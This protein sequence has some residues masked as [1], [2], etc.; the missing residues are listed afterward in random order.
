ME[1]SVEQ[2]QPDSSFPHVTF[3]HAGFSYQSL[4]TFF[5]LGTAK[6][7]FRYPI[8]PNTRS[9]FY[10]IRDT[11]KVVCECFR[12]PEKWG[13]GHTVPIVAEELSMEQIFSTIRDVTDKDVHFV[14]LPY[15]E[16]LLKLHRETVNNLR[17]H[18]EV[19]SFDK[20]QMEKTKEIWPHMKKFADLLRETRW[21]ME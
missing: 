21:F 7:E 14:P 8:L 1:R 18:N 19:G 11:G 12:H 15:D 9:P 4:L 17:W 6:L 3:I 2:L 20:R 13:G 5:V 10:D 16:A